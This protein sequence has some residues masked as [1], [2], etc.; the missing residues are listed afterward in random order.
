MKKTIFICLTS[1]IF[2]GCSTADQTNTLDFRTD[3][4]YNPAT[5]IP[6]GSYVYCEGAG[7][8]CSIQR[9]NE[10][11][12]LQYL[13]QLLPSL[14]TAIAQDK[15]ADFFQQPEAR[16]MFPGLFTDNLGMVTQIIE[17]KPKGY[18]LNNDKM[19]VLQKNRKLPFSQ[20]NVL[21]AIE[22]H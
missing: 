14:R 5:G 22:I 8:T 12:T 2:A 16:Q 9:K 17:L 21:F 13:E 11:E 20:D 10:L 6:T 7:T 15:I 18:L 3:F 1:V 4:T 19:L